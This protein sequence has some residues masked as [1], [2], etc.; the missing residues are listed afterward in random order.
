MLKS[1]VL[2]LKQKSILIMQNYIY[3]VKN[4]PHHCVLLQLFTFVRE[5]TVKN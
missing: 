2:N 4:K 5:S 3:K 1:S